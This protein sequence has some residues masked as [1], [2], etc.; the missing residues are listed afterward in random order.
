ME[1]SCLHLDRAYQ[2]FTYMSIQAKMVYNSGYCS[3]IFSPPQGYVFKVCEEHVFMI[4]ENPESD[5]LLNITL[6]LKC[7][8]C[9]A[10]L[11][12]ISVV[13]FYHL[14]SGGSLLV[15]SS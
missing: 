6:F 2:K 10:G 13:P 8:K 3:F 14:L 11:C 12:G 4:D 5:T 9:C 1:C 7:G 15:V